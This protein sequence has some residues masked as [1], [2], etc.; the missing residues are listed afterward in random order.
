VEDG[1]GVGEGEGIRWRNVCLMAKLF[2]LA[3][4]GNILLLMSGQDHH[5]AAEILDQNTKIGKT[6]KPTVVITSF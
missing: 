6:E 1:E 2:K 3:Y 5:Q 4:E